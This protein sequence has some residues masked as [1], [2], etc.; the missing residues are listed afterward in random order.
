MSPVILAPIP[1]TKT[2][3]DAFISAV[4]NA[5]S[6]LGVEDLCEAYLF[7]DNAVVISYT[8]ELEPFIGFTKGYNP[9]DRRANL[10]LDIYVLTRVAEALER[11]GRD[12]PGGRVFIRKDYV[13]IK[14]INYQN[15][16]CLWDWKG[17]DPVSGIKEA[18]DIALENL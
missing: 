1:I 13:F 9:P 4:T 5:L 2:N 16:I 12:I 11:Y 18:Y 3:A 7:Q 15:V 10:P 14:D 17:R 8:N 6:K